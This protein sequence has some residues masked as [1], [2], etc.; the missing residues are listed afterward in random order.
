M[1]KPAL[2][3][4]QWVTVATDLLADKP[5][6]WANLGLWTPPSSEANPNLSLAYPTA[7]ENLAKAHGDAAGL[8][9]GHKLLDVA[10]GRGGSLVFWHDVYGL[11]HMDALEPSQ[12]SSE[13]IRN[14]NGPLNPSIVREVYSHPMEDYLDSYSRSGFPQKSPIQLRDPGP[15]SW[16][17]YDRV[18][19]LDSAYHFRSHLDFLRFGHLAL[20]KGGLLVWSNFYYDQPLTPLSVKM[21]RWAG[22]HQGAIID[23]DKFEGSV[24]NLGFKVISRLPL[25]TSVMQGFAW[26]VKSRRHQISW[27]SRFQK[28]WLTIEGTAAALDYFARPKQMGYGLYVLEKVVDPLGKSS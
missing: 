20:K 11:T 8:T 28:S 22:I 15:L 2:K 21:L 17:G 1:I 12:A 7:C 23:Q 10:A 9:P 6:R 18:L 16:G 24:Q 14:L 13:L 25:D 4:P 3:E 26:F 5:Q 27:R 19:C